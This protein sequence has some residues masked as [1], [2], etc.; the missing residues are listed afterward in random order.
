MGYKVQQEVEPRSSTSSQEIPG[1][2][3][4]LLFVC[5]EVSPV[6]RIFLRVPLT[7]FRLLPLNKSTCLSTHTVAGV[8]LAGSYRDG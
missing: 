1:L 4:L 7:L 6:Q 2:V 3:L 5:L 8:D